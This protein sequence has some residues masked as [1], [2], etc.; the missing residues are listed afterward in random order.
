M[1]AEEVSS[2]DSTQVITYCN[3]FWKDPRPVRLSSEIGQK[4]QTD[5]NFRNIT[6]L[7]FQSSASK[8]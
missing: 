8:Y 5:S 4:S 1:S 2:V 3:C 6:N 7:G